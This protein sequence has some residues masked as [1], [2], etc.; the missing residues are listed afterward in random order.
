VWPPGSTDT[1]CPR[2]LLAL[3]FDR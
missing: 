3:T 1:V 2:P